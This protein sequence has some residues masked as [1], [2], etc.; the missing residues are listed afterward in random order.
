MHTRGALRAYSVRITAQCGGLRPIMYTAVYLNC[1]Y[2]E[3]TTCGSEW[4]YIFRLFFRLKFRDSGFYNYV[5][6]FA[7]SLLCVP[8]YHTLNQHISLKNDVQNSKKTIYESRVST[9]NEFR[10]NIR[11]C[12]PMIPHILYEPKPRASRLILPRL[13]HFTHI[14][15]SLKIAHDNNLDKEL[16]TPSSFTQLCETLE[17]QN[18]HCIEHQV[19]HKYLLVTEVGF[20]PTPQFHCNALSQ[21]LVSKLFFLANSECE[22]LAVLY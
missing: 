14:V 10:A 9:E 6:V 18:C 8:T 22:N 21:N 2:T 7:L 16:W 11:D 4:S 20:E 5:C 15:K 17:K 12:H 1:I 13:I 3:P 19:L